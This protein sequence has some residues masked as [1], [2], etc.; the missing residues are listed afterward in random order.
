MKQ[1]KFYYNYYFFEDSG[2]NCILHLNWTQ[3][4]SWSFIYLVTFYSRKK[5]ANSREQWI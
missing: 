1:V 4:T 2:S 5:S 3:T